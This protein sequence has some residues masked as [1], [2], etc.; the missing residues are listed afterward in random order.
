MGP[1]GDWELETAGS[2]IHSTHVA[3]AGN[4]TQAYTGL[5]ISYTKEKRGPV[6]SASWD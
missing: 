5:N 3:V 6:S 1:E 4:L 2:S